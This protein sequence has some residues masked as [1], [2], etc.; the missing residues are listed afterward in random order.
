MI[1]MI[2]NDIPN[3][4]C[5]I[6][7]I[8]KEKQEMRFLVLKK[9]QIGRLNFNFTRIVYEFLKLGDKHSIIILNI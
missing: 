5:K 3:W 2:L 6:V 1:L 9:I 7:T 8:G 4:V